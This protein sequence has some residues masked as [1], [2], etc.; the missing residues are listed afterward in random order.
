VDQIDQRLGFLTELKRAKIREAMEK[1]NREEVYLREKSWEENDELTPEEK[2]RLREIQQEKEKAIESILSP[3]ELD[4]FNLWYSP[5][6]YHVRDAMLA[7]NNT[8][9]EFLGVY[10]IQREFDAHW[11]DVDPQELTGT[12]AAAYQAAKQ[13]YNT[14]LWNFLGP[15]RYADFQ[16]SQDADYRELVRAAEQYNLPDSAAKSVYALKGIVS[17]QRSK[18]QGDS[19][20]SAEMKSNVLNEISQ[21]TERQVAQIIGSKPLRSY[22]RSGAGK[23]IIQ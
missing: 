20:L 14:E 19:S 21:E 17:A 6:A 22:L 8:E 16:R 18:I 3:D 4:Q 9:D 23:W 1:A 10:R 7:M 15:D 5:S 2:T 13:Q 11:A 12:E